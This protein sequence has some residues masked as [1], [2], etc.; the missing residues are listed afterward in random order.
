MDRSAHPTMKLARRIISRKHFVVGNYTLGTEQNREQWETVYTFLPSSDIKKYVKIKKAISI[1]HRCYSIH[2]FIFV[3]RLFLFLFKNEMLYHLFILVLIFFLYLTMT[4][5]ILS[6]FYVFWRFFYKYFPCTLRTISFIRNFV[7]CQSAFR[8]YM[9][10][11]VLSD[12]KCV[13]SLSTVPDNF[14]FE[15][16]LKDVNQKGQSSKFCPFCVKNFR[17]GKKFWDLRKCIS[18]VKGIFYL[19]W[20][21]I[22]LNNIILEKHQIF[23]NFLKSP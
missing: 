16:I 1:Y 20:L 5:F 11:Y 3:I 9:N 13:I 23:Y 10:K 7:D 19:D 12:R 8:K 14:S 18:L 21:N 4:I 22:F 15:K 17:L 2:I 6:H